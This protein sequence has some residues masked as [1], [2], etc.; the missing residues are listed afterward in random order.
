MNRPLISYLLY[1]AFAYVGMLILFTIISFFIAS[2][3]SSGMVIAPFLSAMM[4]GEFFI[5]KEHRA[6]NNSE[7]H[8][9]T[10]GSF[11]IFAVLNLA[12]SGLVFF[13]GGFAELQS[14]SDGN[15]ILLILIG[16]MCLVLFPIV[17]F[18]MRWAYGGLTRKRAA[19][20]LGEQ[21]KTFD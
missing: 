4:I 13:G 21:N 19:K 14:E 18:M 2:A 6:P 5:K 1:F 15:R 8:F 10:L 20:L 3:G 7:R 16:V 11:A 17:F 9:L 12:L